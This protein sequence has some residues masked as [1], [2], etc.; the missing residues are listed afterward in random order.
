MNRINS[1]IN[2]SV[3]TVTNTDIR[4]TDVTEIDDAGGENNQE[5]GGEG[6]GPNR[7]SGEDLV[8]V[9]PM[10][11][12]KPSNLEELNEWLKSRKVG[13]KN[14][15]QI[16]KRD[17]NLALSLALG[18]RPKDRQHNGVYVLEEEGKSKK[19]QGVADF[20][21]NA[22]LAATQGFWQIVELQITDT[23]GEFIVW[24]FTGKSQLQKLRILVPRTLY[25]NC[26]GIHI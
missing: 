21:K 8:L 16:K 4:V 23:L 22:A 24:A 9:P 6:N 17:R 20:V 10:M 11:T 5:E 1:Q 2:D 25:V 14:T 7:V 18:N 15:R 26:I 13:W 3:S 19:P 12:S